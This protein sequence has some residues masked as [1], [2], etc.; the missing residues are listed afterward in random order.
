MTSLSSI[1]PAKINL[2]LCITGKR[3]DGYHLLDST[4]S[5]AEWGDEVTVTPSDALL[6]D[7][8]GTFADVAGGDD[9]NLALRAARMLQEQHAITKG[10]QIRLVKHI[11]VGAGL[12]GGSSD[13]A[14]TLKLLN[15]LWEL[16][17]SLE[18][19]CEI[20]VTL[21]AD[22]PACLYGVPLRMRGIGEKIDVLPAHPNIPMLL[23]NP[24]K[25]LPTA[26]VYQ[27]YASDPAKSDALNSALWQQGVSDIRTFFQIIDGAKNH[28]QRSAIA[29]MTEIAEML[30]QLEHLPGAR[31]TTLCGSGASC[32]ALFETDEQCQ[33]ARERT[34][35][36]HPRWWLQVTHLKG[37]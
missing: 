25:A 12:G 29:N 21:G 5:F 8:S 17:L 28:L 18:E 10:A 20:G 31:F 33:S 14:A 11:P 32:M 26:I 27:S 36:S 30:L 24:K 1:A 16:D 34:A 13:A 7:M 6:F 9:D 3:D 2:S 22:V 19:L 37:E 15:E 35:K 23:V 4:V